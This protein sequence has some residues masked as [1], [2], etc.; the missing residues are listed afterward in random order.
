MAYQ[1]RASFSSQQLPLNSLF[2]VEVILEYNF[3]SSLPSK[4]I[5]A[6][7]KRHITSTW[8]PLQEANYWRLQVCFGGKLLCVH[9]WQWY[10]QFYVSDLHTNIFIS[11]LCFSVVLPLAKIYYSKHTDVLKKKKKAVCNLFQKKTHNTRQDHPYFH[12]H[13]CHKACASQNISV[14]LLEQSSA[15]WSYEG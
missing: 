13:C 12:A 10:F 11:S 15:T 4:L 3:G 1:Q 5:S 6:Q 14:M 7:H 2:E 9:S 8:T